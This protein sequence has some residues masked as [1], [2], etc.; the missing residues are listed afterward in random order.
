MAAALFVVHAKG[1]LTVSYAVQGCGLCLCKRSTE[2]SYP[3]QNQHQL[4]QYI[5]KF[6]GKNVFIYCS[7]RV[8]R[9]E[10]LTVKGT[11]EYRCCFLTCL[12]RA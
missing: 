7:P 2:L 3:H 10:P 8:N 5:S 6:L 1:M 4:N 11:G 9:G 12:L